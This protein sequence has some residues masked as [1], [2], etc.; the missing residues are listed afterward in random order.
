MLILVYFPPCFRADY[1]KQISARFKLR[2][3][4]SN[5]NVT[6]FL[7]SSFLGGIMRKKI[8]WN[9][10]PSA[11]QKWCEGKTGVPYVDANMRELLLTGWMSNRGRQNV[12]SFLVKDLGLDWRLGAEWFESL[13]VR[14]FISVAAHLGALCW[15]QRYKRAFLLRRKIF[16]WIEIETMHII[17]LNVTLLFYQ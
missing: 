16:M 10:D 7:I 1:T 5:V 2:S 13:L 14:Y 12:A 11:L 6:A 8:K 15:I 3:S 9:T 4:E 17:L